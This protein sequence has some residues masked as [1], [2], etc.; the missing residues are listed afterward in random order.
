MP[1][2]QKTVFI[3]Y[4]HEPAWAVARLVYENLSEHD[5]DV[6]IDVE[7]MGSGRFDTILLRQIEARA[8]FILILTPGTVERCVETGDWLRRE[9]EHAIDTER[10]IVPLFAYG[11]SF[12]GTE[13]YLT[14]KLDQL[15][16]RNGWPLENRLFKAAM[17]K[18][19]NQFLQQPFSG[20]LKPTPT[21]DQAVVQRK[22][23]AVATQPIPT[24]EQLNAEEYFS[25]AEQMFLG[26]DFDSAIFYYGEAIRI[27]PQYSKAYYHRG[28]ALDYEFFL[29]F[30]VADYS[31]AIHLDPKYVDAYR[32]RGEIYFITGKFDKA[33]EDF[34][35]AINLR[36]NDKAI[37]SDLA[38]THYALDQESEAK[39]IWHILL[40]QD[41][42]FHLANQMGNRLI[43]R[44]E[45]IEAARKLIAEL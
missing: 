7:T 17:E 29:D 12:D 33:L 5:Y 31:E 30:A 42:H 27:N 18:V 2:E 28:L 1:D 36:H 9:I 16:L 3:S 44:T 21:S 41:E 20:I 15:H 4:R 22:I 6:F 40:A 10:N 37:L 32:D 26:A 23:D 13:K 38:L 34:Q 35:Q 11:F 43:P 25:R 45:L 19:R 24:P 39:R 14:G 8:H